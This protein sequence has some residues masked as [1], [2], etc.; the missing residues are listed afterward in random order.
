MNKLTIAALSGTALLA[1]AACE[2]SEPVD[3]EE[4]MMTDTAME[5]VDPVGTMPAE[6]TGDSVTI[7]EAGVDARINDGNTSVTA[8]VDGDPSMT[9][10][11]E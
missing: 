8:D 1:L 11:T 5:P 4:E 7:G 6:E 2:Q 3:A 9:V 10:E